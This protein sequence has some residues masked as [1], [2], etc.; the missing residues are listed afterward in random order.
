MVSCGGEIEE[1]AAFTW[2]EGYQV[3]V[4]GKAASL[5]EALERLAPEGIDL[6]LLGSEFR[7]VELALFILDARRRGFAGLVVH[8]VS[9]IGAMPGSSPQRE[10]EAAKPQSG[11]GQLDAWNAK[12]SAEATG[13]YGTLSFTEK[14]RAVFLR[15]SNGWTNKQIALDLKCSE[16]SVKAIIQQLFNK[17]GV[18]KRTKIVR[19]AF[20]AGFRSAHL[21]ERSSDRQ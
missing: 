17:I 10:L 4:A 1:N 20:E 11:S 14:Q 16:G 19:M 9:S 2:L 15:V 6:V 13:S 12:A 21:R 7:E 18:R 5:L 8:V 3:H